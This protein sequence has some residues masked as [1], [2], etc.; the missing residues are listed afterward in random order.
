[1]AAIAHQDDIAVRPFRQRVAFEDRPFMHRR[2]GVQ[3]G[4]HIGM[5]IGKRSA[6]VGHIAGFRPGFDPETR[7]RL[8][9]REIDLVPRRGDVI[10]HDMA[11]RPPPLGAVVHQLVA[12][13]Q[14]R[15]DRRPVRQS[16]G[17]PRL[18]NAQHPVAH[19]RMHAVGGDDRIVGHRFPVFDTQRHIAVGLV[20]T[21]QLMAVPD[22][23]VRHRAVQRR[24]QIAPVHQDI[25]HAVALKRVRPQRM[26]VGQLAGVVIAI[27]P[28][29]RFER[30]FPDLLA[31]ADAVEH[32]HGVGAHLDTRADAGKCGRLLVDR[33]LDPDL[34]QTGGDGQAAD[35]GADNRD[36][37]LGGH[38]IS[39]ARLRA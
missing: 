26:I 17:K 3:H 14:L 10:D 37:G 4:A 19:R 18:L 16:T 12:V 21:A 6:K 5:K 31:D 38:T 13:E 7:L 22:R 25:G 29:R 15:R 39:L 35:T 28:V 33:R 2:A 8:A 24:V 11:V 27:A 32:A 34:A 36:F 1:M 20:D 30:R 9:G 23:L